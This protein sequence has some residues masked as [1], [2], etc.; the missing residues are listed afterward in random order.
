MKITTLIKQLLIFCLLLI[1]SWIMIHLIAVFGI[2]LVFAIPLLQLIFY[3]N[4]Y[5]FWC[6]IRSTP[7]SFWHSLIDSLIVLVITLISLGLVYFEARLLTSL[8][9]PFTQKTVQFVIPDKNEYKLGEIFPVKIDIKG[10]KVPINIVRADLQFDPNLTEVIDI[11]TDAS[12]AS[13]FIQKDINNDLGYARLTGGIPN[14]GFQDDAGTFGIVYMRGKRPGPIEVNFLPSSLVLANDGKGTNVLVDLP[15]ATYFVSNVEISPEQKQVQDKLKIN[16]NVL[17]ENSET[18]AK[19]F[20][21]GYRDPTPP[22]PAVLGA[23]S[24]DDAPSHSTPTRTTPLLTLLANLDN[25]IISWWT[26]VITY[27]VHLFKL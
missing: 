16:S 11:A 6:R 10:V 3:P 2:F 12:F 22:L 24:S 1:T 14:P 25:L 23:N 15:K 7:H 18:Q 19:L 21:S 17:G 5:C 27:L 20:F 4:I 8:N 9:L 26:K 13:I